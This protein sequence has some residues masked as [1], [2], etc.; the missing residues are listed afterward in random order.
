MHTSIKLSQQPWNKALSTSG[1]WKQLSLNSDV[2]MQAMFV[3]VSL[4]LLVYIFNVWRN[5]SQLTHRRTDILNLKI[6]IFN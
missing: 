2:Q 1:W 6:F 3:A 5:F 4:C